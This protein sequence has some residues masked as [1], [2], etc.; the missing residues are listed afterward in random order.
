V[1]TRLRDYKTHHHGTVIFTTNHFAPGL[2]DLA[3]T[4]LILGQNG[5][6]GPT[7]EMMSHPYIQA[8]LTA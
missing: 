6:I 8:L 7:T 2:F 4:I 1:V 3:D 5:G